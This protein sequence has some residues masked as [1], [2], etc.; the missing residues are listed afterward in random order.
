[1]IH[2]FYRTLFTS[3]FPLVPWIIFKQAAQFE[4]AA[5][6]DCG[7]GVECNKE[8]AKILYKQAMLR[9]GPA[10][11]KTSTNNF[12][13]KAKK[14]M[15]SAIWQHKQPKEF[16]PKSIDPLKTPRGKWKP[17]T[18]DFGKRGRTPG[19]TKRPNSG[20]LSPTSGEGMSPPV[21][22]SAATSPS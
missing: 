20:G 21:S 9:F 13:K 8:R 14:T 12:V 22:P 3:L 11:L 1:M 7:R 15:D 17:Q 19:G 18:Y 10:G 2:L 6:Y 4:V 16:N 5:M